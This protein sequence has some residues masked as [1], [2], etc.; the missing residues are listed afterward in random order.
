MNAKEMFEKLGYTR[1]LDSKKIGL[2]D[3]LVTC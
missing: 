2:T 1:N 3:T